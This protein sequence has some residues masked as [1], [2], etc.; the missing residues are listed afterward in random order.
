MEKTPF[1]H[2]KLKEIREKNHLTQK[3]V[4]SLLGVPR[5]TYAN[6]ETGN[7]EPEMSV[8]IKFASKLNISTEWLFGFSDNP[9]INRE[10]EK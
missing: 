3:E 8:L 5:S 4:A 2:L 1:L 10:Q 9:E 7:R 6:Y